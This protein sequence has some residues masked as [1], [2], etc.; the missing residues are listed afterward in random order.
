MCLDQ[1]SSHGNVH[2]NYVV[3]SLKMQIQIYQV[4]SG[5]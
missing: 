4:W 2:T 3:V 1:C 5:A